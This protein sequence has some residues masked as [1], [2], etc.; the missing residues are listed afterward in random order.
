MNRALPGASFYFL[1]KNLNTIGHYVESI[2]QFYVSLLRYYDYV[3]Y[4]TLSP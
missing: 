4:L 3:Q 2:Y 1:L